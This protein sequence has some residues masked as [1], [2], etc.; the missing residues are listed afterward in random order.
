MPFIQ[1]NIDRVYVELP[2]FIAENDLAFYRN[3][4]NRLKSAGIKHFSLSHLSQKDLLPRGAKFITNENVYVFNDA[5][6]QFIKEQGAENSIF[7][8]ENDIVN[9]AKGTNRRGIVPLYYYPYLFYSRMPVKAKKEDFFSDRTGERFRKIIRDGITIVL[10]EHPVSLTQYKTKLERYGFHHFLIDL[11]TTSP[12]KNT[13][14]T[15]VG[16][17]LKSEQIQPSSNF[18]FKRELK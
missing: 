18:N 8:Y 9:L 17:L 13:P 3:Q 5:A 16:R 2:R 1:K 15:I 14:K 10:P 12:S 7:P 4:L 11:G 6:I